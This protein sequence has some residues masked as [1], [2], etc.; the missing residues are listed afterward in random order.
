VR[1][2]ASRAGHL[3]TPEIFLV[4]ISVGGCVEP[5]AIL[6]LERLCQLQNPIFSWL[7]HSA[8]TSYATTFR[9]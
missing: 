5:R 3:L 2:S 8:S 1:L 4:L 6:R 7:R 9:S